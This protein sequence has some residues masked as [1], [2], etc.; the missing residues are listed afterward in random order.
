[1]SITLNDNTS[2][3]KELLTDTVGGKEVEIVKI[4]VGIAGADSL[5]SATNPI[6]AQIVAGSA[7]IGT[8]SL[9]GSTSVV[10]TSH[11]EVTLTGSYV[12]H[13]GNA[14]N[15]TLG[16]AIS[17][18]AGVAAIGSVTVTS[19]PEISLTG[20]YVN[21]AGN[22]LNVTLGAAVSLA[23][24]TNVIGAV[25]L[26]GSYIDNTSNALRVSMVAGTL[27]T[28]P[29]VSLTGSWVDHT[30]NAIRIT[31]GAAFS[32]AAGTAVIGAVSLVA[33]TAV[34]GSV[35]LTGSYIDNTSNALRISMV[36]GTLSTIPEVSLTG[37]WVD[38]TGNAIRITQGAAFSLAAGTAVIGAVSLVAGT[39]VI[40]SVSLTGSYIDNTSNAIRVSLLAGTVTINAI[41]AGTN[42]IGSVSLTGSVSA[43]VQ[44]YAAQGASVAGNP[45][46]SGAEGRTTVPT[47][48]TDGQA[49]RVQ[50]DD[51]GRLVVVPN[52]ARDYVSDTLI[53]I[54]VSTTVTLI[55]AQAASTFADLTT[56]VITNGNTG[57]TTAIIYDGI[58]AG[59]QRL[60]LQLAGNGGGAVINFPTPLKQ[61][62]AATGWG[63]KLDTVGPV[64]VTSQFIQNK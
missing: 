8:V 6:F 16:A 55:T 32:L 28:I 26:T 42:N 5:M 9:T 23:A 19:T 39:A 22:A 11:P 63:I 44:G 4:N 35:S 30:G 64:Y 18:A 45:L 52:G 29:E 21:H 62:V 54:T 33:G 38:H 53:T 1:M 36:A 7:N 37:S 24:G 47:A 50:A 46:L 48:V 34:I 41:P 14:L 61:A 2:V 15:V 40:G 25:S 49:V 51:L 20:S 57:M 3:G 17:L 31:Q 12:N 58:S 60:V 27:S 56:L 43:M 10:V 13:T 59:T